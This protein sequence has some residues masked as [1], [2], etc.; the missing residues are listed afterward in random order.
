MYLFEKRND[1]PERD[2]TSDLTMPADKY[3]GT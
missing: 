3:I 1:V 2:R